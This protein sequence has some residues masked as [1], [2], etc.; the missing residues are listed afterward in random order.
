MKVKDGFI[1]KDVELTPTAIENLQ[2]LAE[3]KGFSLKK[4]M[5]IAL[6]K[7]SRKNIK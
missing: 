2:A 4:Y 3:K 6:T 7:E 1:R 5:E